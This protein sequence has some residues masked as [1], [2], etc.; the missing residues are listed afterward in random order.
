[1][2]DLVRSA[3]HAR[4]ARLPQLPPE[5][6]IHDVDEEEEANDSIG[7]LPSSMGPPKYAILLSIHITSQIK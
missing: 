7:A 1:M 6:T 2:S 5:L 4:I 3:M